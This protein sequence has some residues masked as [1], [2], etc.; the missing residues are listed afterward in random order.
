MTSTL[1]SQ[2]PLF[3]AFPRK[4]L[5][6]KRADLLLGLAFIRVPA[7]Q[8]EKMS[9]DAW[10]DKL[11]QD[12]RALLLVLL[13][14]PSAE[15]VASFTVLKSATTPKKTILYLSAFVRKPLQGKD[16]FVKNN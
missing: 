4:R 13:H 5:T 8:A 1:G 15:C 3:P 10:E 12:E 2:T 11:F 16:E 9:L 14:F 7:K 6:Q